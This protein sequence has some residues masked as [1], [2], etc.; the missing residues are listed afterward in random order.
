MGEFLH[1]PPPMPTIDWS[2]NIG[3]PWWKNE[4]AYKKGNLTAKTRKIKL[5]NMLTKQETTIEVCSEE[6]LE[7]IQRRYMAYNKHSGSYTWKRTDQDK[8]ARLLNMRE[9]LAANGI[10]DEDNQ[11][12]LLNLDPDSWIP[13]IHLY[14]SDDLTVA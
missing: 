3:K 14:F 1:C 10:P 8:V 4:K 9:T 7:E 13:I 12:D 6:T 11:F 2:S 5:Y